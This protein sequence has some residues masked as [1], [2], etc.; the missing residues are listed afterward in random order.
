M[1]GPGQRDLVWGDRALAGD[2]GE[3]R[4]LLPEV[5]GPC[6]AAQGAPGEDRDV[7]GLALLEDGQRAERPR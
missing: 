7:L 4:E 1:Q 5:G 6:A 2:R 3:L